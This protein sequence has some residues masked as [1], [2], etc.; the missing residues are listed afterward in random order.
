[1]CQALAVPGYISEWL[2]CPKCSKSSSV[3]RMTSRKKPRS[4]ACVTSSLTTTPS[5]AFTIAMSASI[6]GAVVAHMVLDGV[7]GG[8]RFA[9]VAPEALQ[10]VVLHQALLDVPVV[11]VSDLE[12]A[13]AGPLQPR[14]HLPHGV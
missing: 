8:D 13:T 6:V 9:G 5:I 1:M 2:H 4:S 14:S 7:V 3:S 12:L 10:H 11:H